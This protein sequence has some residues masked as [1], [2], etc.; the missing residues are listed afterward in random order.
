M[1]Q[2]LIYP[3]IK[4][5]KVVSPCNNRCFIDSKTG[6]CDGCQ[7]TLQEVVDWETASDGEKLL[8]LNKIEKRKK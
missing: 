5:N 7:R 6:L 2:H 1:S 8:I 3:E 4:S